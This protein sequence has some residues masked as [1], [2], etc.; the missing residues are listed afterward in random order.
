LKLYKNLKNYGYK[1]KYILFENG[2][3]YDEN[4]KREIK[5]DSN[6]RFLIQKNTGEMVRISLKSLYR[7][8]YR[9]E[10]AKDNTTD[11]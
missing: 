9:T 4:S 2:I 6:N 8:V 1:D 5:R 11:L 3:L 10:Y 7:V